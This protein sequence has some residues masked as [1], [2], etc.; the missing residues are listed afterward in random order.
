[1]TSTMTSPTERSL[2]AARP[3][4]FRS[5]PRAAPRVRASN[6]SRSGNARR[7]LISG[8]YANR[9]IAANCGHRERAIRA[10]RARILDERSAHRERKRH[11]REGQRG[12]A[13]GSAKGVRVVREARM[14]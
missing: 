2:A 7:R 9:Y 8:E 10:L 3:A 4:F 14:P 13:R 1:M 12:R 5:A 11:R 6:S